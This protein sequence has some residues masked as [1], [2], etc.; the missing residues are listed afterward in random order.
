MLLAFN[1]IISAFIIICLWASSILTFNTVAIMCIASFLIGVVM[2]EGQSKNALMCYF[3]V[4]LIS[5][6]LP[7]NRINVLMFVLFFGYYPVVKSLI[8]RINRLSIEMIIKFLLFSLVAFSGI[9]GYTKLFSANVS[10]VLP[11]W[12]VAFVAV[13]FFGIFDYALSMLL[14]YYVNK[15]RPRIKK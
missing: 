10:E 15:I 7:L 8:E 9:Y 6:I 3:S 11:W 14:A 2:I 1:G 5:L 4:S 13:L 12:G